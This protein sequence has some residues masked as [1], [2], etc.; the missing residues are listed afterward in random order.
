[1]EIVYPN[2][3]SKCLKFYD[4]YDHQYHERPISDISGLNFIK[5]MTG[6]GFQSM[7]NWKNERKGKLL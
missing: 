4:L 3:F 1:M 5:T 2:I 6:E 7:E